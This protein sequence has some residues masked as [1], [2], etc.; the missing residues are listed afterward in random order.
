[1]LRSLV[2]WAE[3]EGRRVA[4]VGG[5]AGSG[6]SRLVREFAIEVAERGALV[7]YG[8]CDAV[9]L[10]P[11]YG[12]FVEA[13]E[14]LDAQPPFSGVPGERVASDPD[15]ERHRLPTG[16]AGL[17]ERLAR[18]RPVLLV[19]EDAH[20]ADTPSLGLL[21][22]LA[23][24]GGRM[25]VLVLATFREEE[26]PDALAETLADLRRSDD[27][28]RLRL[29]GLSTDEVEEFVRRAGGEPEQ[30]AGTI[31]ALT[32]GQSR[33]LVCGLWRSLADGGQARH[34][35]ERA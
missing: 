5:E 32:G 22:H 27:I 19:I 26:L 25:R 2:P 20:W 34:A 16:V 3:G 7:L 9:V 28:V 24:A 1:M 35:G 15:T 10:Y 11:P 12:P 29:G 13:F 33:S 6:K 8:A 30:L 18:E 17:L 21:R 31:N 4:L 23:R 14:P